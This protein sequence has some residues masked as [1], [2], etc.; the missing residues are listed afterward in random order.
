MFQHIRKSEVVPVNSFLEKTVRL[1]KAEDGPTAVQYA[2]MILTVVLALLT[3]ITSIGQGT[4]RNVEPMERPALNA[5]NA[6]N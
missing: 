5:P 1:I 4:A 6:G 3:T 2:L